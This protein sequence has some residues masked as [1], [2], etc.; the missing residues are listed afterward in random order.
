MIEYLPLV[1]TG[2]G[3]IISLLYYTNIIRNANRQRKTQTTLML[4]IDYTQHPFGDVM[5]MEWTDYEDFRRKYDST[6]NLENYKQRWTVWSHFDSIG[7]MLNQKLINIDAIYH[8]LNG[9]GVLL[10]W[11]KFKPIIYAHREYYNEPLWFEWWENLAEEIMK[12]RES[13]GL[14]KNIT[15]PDNYTK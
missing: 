11:N 13:I 15:D 5:L 1:L 4:Q 9:Y 7:Y 3:I 12:Y 10:M 2:I 14:P 6:V 8:V